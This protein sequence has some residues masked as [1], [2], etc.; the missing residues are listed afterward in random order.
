MFWPLECILRTDPEVMLHDLS[1]SQSPGEVQSPGA[2]EG[3]AA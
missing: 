3:G 2:V 1:L